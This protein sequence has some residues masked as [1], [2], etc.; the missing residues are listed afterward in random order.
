M[1]EL[2][3]HHRAFAGEPVAGLP[4]DQLPAVKIAASGLRSSCPSHGEELIA[5]ADRALQGREKV[6]TWYWAAPRAQRGTHCAQ[7]RA[8]PN[9]R[10]SSVTLVASLPSLAA[11]K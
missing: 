3:A 1:A 9:G 10:S 7:E 2:P 4:V 11:A 8:H 6:R 5:V